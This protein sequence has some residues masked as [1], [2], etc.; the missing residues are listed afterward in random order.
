[1]ERV[2]SDDAACAQ[3]DQLA[4]FRCV[5]PAQREIPL[6]TTEFELLQYFLRHPRRVLSREAILHAVWGNEFDHPTNVVDVYVGYLRKKV[7]VP[8]D[9]PFIRTVRGVGY[10]VGLP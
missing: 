1:M 2:V 3:V 8:F 5:S 4:A 7:E 6:S 10:G 9:R